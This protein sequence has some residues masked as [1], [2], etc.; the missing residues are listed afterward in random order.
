MSIRFLVF[1]TTVFCHSPESI[2]LDIT[3]EQYFVNRLIDEHHDELVT[4]LKRVFAER[5]VAQSR[6]HRAINN[7]IIWEAECS[8][9][10]IEAL[11]A[12]YRGMLLDLVANGATVRSARFQ[13]QKALQ[14]H[15]ADTTAGEAEVERR[16]IESHAEFGR[17]L[18]ARLLENGLPA[19]NQDRYAGGTDANDHPH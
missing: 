15:F 13:V 8:L 7:T 9:V 2:A 11:G 6:M 16:L 3:R 17:C 14:N 18:D 19:F 1:L 4:S 5:G 12:G 10:S